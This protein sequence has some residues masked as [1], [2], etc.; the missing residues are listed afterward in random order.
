MIQVIND[1]SNKH[2]PIVE[3]AVKVRG[4][5][6]FGESR[7]ASNLFRYG[8][9]TIKIILNSF[10]DYRP[11]GLCFFLSA[12]IG[13]PGL[14]LSAFFISQLC[15]YR[16]IHSP[17]MGRIL[18]LCFAVL[19]LPDSRLGI[20]SRYVCPHAP[21]PGGDSLQSQAVR[22]RGESRREQ[23]TFS[24]TRPIRSGT[25][26]YVSP[27]AVWSRA[28]TWALL[29]SISWRDVTSANPISIRK[30][31]IVIFLG[32]R[33]FSRRRFCCIIVRT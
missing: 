27:M 20:H 7:V 25:G 30:Q 21:E 1:P 6:E 29:R 23:L 5:R 24:L 11:F 12:M 32:M 9:Q 26:L 8:Y 16:R 4:T 31:G 14:C 13:L 3:V 28:M 2:V 18:G 33:V 17:Q 10:R 22:L 19:C 15:A